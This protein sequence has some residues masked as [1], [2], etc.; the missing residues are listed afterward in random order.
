MLAEYNWRASFNPRPPCEERPAGCVYFV[1]KALFQSTPPLR[2][3]TTTRYAHID[4]HQVSIH[5]PPARSDNQCVR[6]TSEHAGF[7]PRPPCEER[8]P[9]W[10]QLGHKICFNPRPPCEERPVWLDTFIPPE[11]FNPRPPC[12]ERRIAPVLVA[13]SCCFNPRPPCEERQHCPAS[14]P[15]EC[16]FQSTPPLRGATIA[17]L[18]LRLPTRSFNPRPPCEERLTDSRTIL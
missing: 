9:E 14:S 18:S 8:L 2:G 16:L 11:S 7:N 17:I 13:G 4:H 15:V 3:A 10:L 5:A 12:E 6:V 1:L